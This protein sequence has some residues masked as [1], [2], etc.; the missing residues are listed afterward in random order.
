MP[1]KIIFLGSPDFAVPTLEK[2]TKDR[3][4]EIVAVFSQPDKKVGRKQIETPSSVKQKALALNLRVF[5][6]TNLNTPENIDL[7]KKLK[8]DFLLTIAY[9][10]ILSEEI[11]H[12]PQIE[13][14]NLHGSLLPKYR[15]ASPI[16][17][18]LLNGE[19]ETGISFIRMIKK[20]DAGEIFYQTK[21]AIANNDNTAS[22]FQK[23][24]DLGA[25]NTPEVLEKIAQKKLIPKIQNEKD[26]TYCQKIKKTDGL[27]DWKNETA[28]T[29]Y[30]KIRAYTPWP[31]CHTF[32]QGK[33]LKI[34]KASFVTSSHF[35]QKTP[36]GTIVELQNTVQISTKAGSLLPEIVQLEGKKPLTIK[37]FLQGK[38]EFFKATLGS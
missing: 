18:A 11:L 14:L 13:A 29:I 26:A 35:K 2:L 10:Q 17:S 22:L 31:G 9:G 16:Q 24:A 30:N 33:T 32:F 23:I 12:I 38:P 6:P 8:P 7:I 21:I 1:Y 34:L 28:E 15:G 36:P 5:T 37:A 4:F 3:R 20:M 19:K 27:I 25:Q